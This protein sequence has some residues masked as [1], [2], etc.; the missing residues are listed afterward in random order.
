M[1]M[2][3]WPYEFGLMGV[4]MFTLL[5][6]VITQVNL[7]IRFIQ[8]LQVTSKVN[9]FLE[10]VIFWQKAHQIIKFLHAG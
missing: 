7:Y 2:W 3:T 6:S 1:C 9:T 10:D 5:L 8:N 4:V